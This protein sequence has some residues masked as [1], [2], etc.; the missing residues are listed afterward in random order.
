MVLGEGAWLALEISWRA[1]RG[2]LEDQILSVLKRVVEELDAEILSLA[3][4]RRAI[5]DVKGGKIVVTSQ[6]TL[7]EKQV[8]KDRISELISRLEAADVPRIQS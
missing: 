4:G 1:W 6:E 5:L 2:L 3:S 7:L 8:F